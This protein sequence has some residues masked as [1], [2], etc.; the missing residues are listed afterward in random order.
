MTFLEAISMAGD[1]DIK[2]DR[3][4]VLL[5][6]TNSDGSREVHR[7]NLQDRKLPHVAILHTPAERLHIRH[8]Q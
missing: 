8:P 3:E 6:R 1:L 5:Y 2:G 7:I 4:N